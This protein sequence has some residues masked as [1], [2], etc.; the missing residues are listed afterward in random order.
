MS[1]GISNTDG[2]IRPVFGTIIQ[3]ALVA[4]G[5]I[6]CLRAISTAKEKS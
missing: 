1:K 5:V 4:C 2:K 6:G 3:W